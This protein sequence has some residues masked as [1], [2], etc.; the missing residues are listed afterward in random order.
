MKALI[1][2]ILAGIAF[3]GISSVQA[4]DRKT[5]LVNVDQKFAPPDCRHCYVV[6]DVKLGDKC[7][8]I[9]FDREWKTYGIEPSVNLGEGNKYVYFQAQQYISGVSAQRISR[10][11]VVESFGATCSSPLT[12]NLFI[13]VD[14][15]I[16][17]VDETDRPRVDDLLSSLQEKYGS[18]SIVENG[19]GG[20]IIQFALD[21]S[22]SPITKLSSLETIGDGNQPYWYT[23]YK[24]RNI[25][26]VAQFEIYPCSD[27]MA[28][29]CSFNTKAEHY[30]LKTEDWVLVSEWK[31]QMAADAEKLA[32]QARDSVKGIVPKL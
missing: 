28:K 17:F 18:P 10:K 21:L 14:R 31:R 25:S 9:S 8:T 30:Q 7:E 24:K 23:G 27:D 15:D 11:K 22:N 2:L 3:A 1:K 6:L 26:V 16:R 32:T 19:D 12:G 20:T 13:S 29:V 5:E 4:K